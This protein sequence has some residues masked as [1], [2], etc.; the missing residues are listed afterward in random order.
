M[1]F[2]YAKIFQWFSF[3]W[4]EPKL[5]SI[6]SLIAYYSLSQTLNSLT[7]LTFTFILLTCS[8]QPVRHCPLY[9][10]AVSLCSVPGV[11]GLVPAHLS[12]SPLGF[13]FFFQEA[14]ILSSLQF[15]SCALSLSSET[16]PPAPMCLNLLEKL[17]RL[18]VLH[19]TESSVRT[20]IMH[21]LLT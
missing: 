5:L 12:D 13:T 3:P 19:E 11:P 4:K 10:H 2:Y 21:F 14:S 7:H 20:Q 15:W 1:R 6:W 16:R 8:L 17:E 18:S 9:R